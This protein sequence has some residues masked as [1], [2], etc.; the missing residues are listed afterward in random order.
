LK[1]AGIAVTVQTGDQATVDG[2]LREGNYDLLITGH[3]LTANPDMEEP[4]P[5]V[6]WSDPAYDAA[7]E[8]STRAVDDEDRRG[9]AWT[10][11]EILATELPVLAL[12][13]PLMWEVY[14]PDVVEPFYTSEGVDGGI[15]LAVN[16]LMFIPC[17]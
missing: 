17:R 16:K 3:G 14:R 13:H 15:P 5:R 2:L 8:A 9:Y 4:A 11:Q 12:W 10:M 7:Y 6:V 1:D